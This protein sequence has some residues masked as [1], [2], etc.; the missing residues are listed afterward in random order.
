MSNTAQ[1]SSSDPGQQYHRDA[2]ACQVPE[3]SLEIVEEK[4][5][6]HANTSETKPD[7]STA[8]GQGKLHPTQLASF[9]LLI[10]VK[11]VCTCSTLSITDRRNEEWQVITDDEVAES[12]NAPIPDD[13]VV[14]A[15]VEINGECVLFYIRRLTK[16]QDGGPS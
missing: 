5:Y 1:P 13:G 11:I 9:I 14:Y 16:E 7:S 15:M 3:E 6:R 12:Q 8:V 4:H 2:A 10:P